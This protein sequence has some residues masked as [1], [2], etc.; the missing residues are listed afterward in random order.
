MT[1]WTYFWLFVPPV[2]L[3]AIGVIFYI[4]SGKR[5]AR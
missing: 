3:V 5:E 1:F 4:I 2:V